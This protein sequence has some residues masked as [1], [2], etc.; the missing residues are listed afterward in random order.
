MAKQKNAAAV[1]RRGKQKSGKQKVE[2]GVAGLK[3]GNARARELTA[4]ERMMC[5][6]K[7]LSRGGYPNRTTLA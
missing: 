3:G 1:A 6:H 7:R 2:I 4:A 5:I